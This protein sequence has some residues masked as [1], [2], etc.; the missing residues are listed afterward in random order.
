MHMSGRKRNLW[1]CLFSA[2]IQTD[3]PYT[4]LLNL[5]IAYSAPRNTRRFYH[6]HGRSPNYIR[7]VTRCD[8][9][10]HRKVFDRRRILAICCD[11]LA[12][13]AYVSRKGT[14]IKLP[15]LFWSGSDV[16]SI[17]F[18]RF[19]RPYVIKPNHACGLIE[20][21][22][23]P[24]SVNLVDI[25]SKCENWLKVCHG[26]KNEEWGY[27]QIKPQIMVEALIPPNPGQQSLVC[28]KFFCY[29]GLVQVVQ[30][31]STYDGIY[32]LTFFNRNGKR[33]NLRKFTSIDHARIPG[34]DPSLHAP[35]SFPNMVQA[36]ETI[37]GPIDHLRVDLY[38]SG[39]AIILSEL[40]V[41]DGSGFSF[42]FNGATPTDC[43]PKPAPH[44][45]I[46]PP[47]QV[48]KIGLREVLRLLRQRSG[49]RVPNM[50]RTG[51]HS[52]DG[53]LR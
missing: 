28:F 51:P 50:D 26:Q 23:D 47:W 30:A 4:N 29:A 3:N 37:A 19:D 43:Q 46:K 6:R 21:V 41:Y 44:Y 45:E 32:R 11:K 52:T 14:A 31:E 16:K 35:A 48:R 39:G 22:D 38:E 34:P 49:K 17:P 42:F 12:A 8:L 20:I 7:P 18:D 25:S 33:L 5:L 9:M 27:S 15:E 40:T 10:Q 1:Y 24:R 53:K 36:A 2:L 13:R